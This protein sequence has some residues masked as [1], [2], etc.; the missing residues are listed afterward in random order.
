MPKKLFIGFVVIIIS[1]F[2]VSGYFMLQTGGI[3]PS[4]KTNATNLVPAAAIENSNY[5]STPKREICNAC[6]GTGWSREDTCFKCNGTGVLDCKECGGTGE[7]QNGTICPY[8][9]GT[10]QIICPACH[11]TG[12]TRCRCCGGDGYYDPQNGDKKA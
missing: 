5:V 8:C 7:Y 3:T 1:I 4:L 10:G 2:G 12:G 6:A 11:G 9:H